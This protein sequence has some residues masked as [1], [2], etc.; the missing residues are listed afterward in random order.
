MNNSIVMN[1]RK[2]ITHGQCDWLFPR[3]KHDAYVRSCSRNTLRVKTQ[4]LCLFDSLI[5]VFY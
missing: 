4:F 3:E 2:K 5:D 1:G